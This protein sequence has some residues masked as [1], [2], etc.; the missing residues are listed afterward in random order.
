MF[1]YNGYVNIAHYLT[2]VKIDLEVI[3]VATIYFSD[4]ET[5]RD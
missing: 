5:G 3:V 1:L 4:Y 2:C